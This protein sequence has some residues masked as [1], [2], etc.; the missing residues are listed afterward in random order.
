MTKSQYN[1]KKTEDA[2]A[3]SVQLINLAKH[4]HFKQ[5]DSTNTWAK[6]HFQ[7]WAPEGVTLITAAEQMGGRGRFKREWVSPANL[8]IY[9]SFCFWLDEKREDVGCISQVLAIAAVKTIESQGFPITIKWPNDLLLRGK[10]MGGILCETI[11]E[12]KKR[13]VV[14]GIGLNVNMPLDALC[15]IDRPATSLLVEAGRAFQVA[16]L[17]VN[18][19]ERF[20]ED[21]TLFLRE[22][23]LPFFPLLHKY[24]ALKKGQIVTFLNHLTRIEG[25][26]E[27]LRPD[28]SIELRFSD[29][30]LK[31]FYSGEINY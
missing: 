20:L 31:V 21:L 9:A 1:S 2:Q 11:V 14:C 12:E 5:I 26:F 16:D 10:K 29:G 13:G 28:G 22:G 18:L 6:C 3:K 8:N 24:S 19:Q 30:S 17:L 4:I 23:F 25:Q 7:Q 15:Q 27:C